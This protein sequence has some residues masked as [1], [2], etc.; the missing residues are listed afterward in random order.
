M[1]TVENTK[2]KFRKGFPATN[3]DLSSLFSEMDL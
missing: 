3:V 2:C 1:K